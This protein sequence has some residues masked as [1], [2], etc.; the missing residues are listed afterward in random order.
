MSRWHRTAART[1]FRSK[2]PTKRFGFLRQTQRPY[3]GTRNIAYKTSNDNEPA[4]TG[5][6]LNIGSNSVFLRD[7]NYRLRESRA[8]RSEIMLKQLQRSRTYRKIVLRGRNLGGCKARRARSISDRADSPLSRA[9]GRGARFSAKSA[10]VKAL[11]CIEKRWACSGGKYL[12]AWA[13]SE[14]RR[15]QKEAI[16]MD[17]PADPG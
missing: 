12:W 9:S 8:G 3:T 16:G 1:Q 10:N 5:Y 11:K 6:I 14:R 17:A 4:Y 15:R 13:R 2:I 7:R